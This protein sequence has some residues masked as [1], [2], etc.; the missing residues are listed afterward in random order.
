MMLT[1]VKRMPRAIG[2]DNPNDQLPAITEV[3]ARGFAN[4]ASG[5][6]GINHFTILCHKALMLTQSDIRT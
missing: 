1:S 5:W 2:S 6:S 3:G 4:I